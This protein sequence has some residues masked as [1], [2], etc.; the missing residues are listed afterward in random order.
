MVQFSSDPSGAEIVIDGNYAGNTP[1]LIK[2]RPG[3]HSIRIT[4]KGYTPWERSIDADA[5]ESRTIAAELDSAK[6]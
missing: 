4:K 3:N 2:L 6:P 1:S 5:G